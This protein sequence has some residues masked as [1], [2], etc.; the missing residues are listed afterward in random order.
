MREAFGVD[1]APQPLPPEPDDQPME[2]EAGVSEA[3]KPPSLADVW[4][5]M[6]AAAA[7]SEQLLA[8]IRS[9]QAT[10][11]A[12]ASLI[13]M[14]QQLAQEAAS[15]TIPWA[16]V[17][18]MVK[19]AL[20]AGGGRSS[21]EQHR[22]LTPKGPATQQARPAPMPTSPAAVAAIAQ[23][24]QLSHSPVGQAATVAALTAGLVYQAQQQ[25]QQQ[26]PCGPSF[27]CSSGAAARQGGHL[28]PGRP[29]QPSAPSPTAPG[30]S[31]AQAPL[32]LI[33]HAAAQPPRAPL[34]SMGLSAAPF[35]G[36][37]RV[38]AALSAQ[39][40]CGSHIVRDKVGSVPRLKKFVRKHAF[41][42]KRLSAVDLTRAVTTPAEE[43]LYWELYPQH[44]RGSRTNYQAMMREW[45]MRVVDSRLSQSSNKAIYLKQVHHLR[46]YEKK[47]VQQL[48]IRDA[49]RFNAALTQPSTPSQQPAP[50]CVLSGAP[51]L[52]HTPT[53]VLTS[54]S[55]P[56]TAFSSQA[57]AQA[58]A[59]TLAQAPTQPPAQANAF[60]AMAAA[61]QQ[62][63]QQQQQHSA[64]ALATTGVTALKTG[65]GRG[66]KGGNKACRGCR[67]FTGVEVQQ[68]PK[69]Q[70]V[71][72]HHKRFQAEQAAR[73]TKKAK[74]GN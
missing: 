25:A 60:T 51:S 24:Q 36:A 35:N 55:T 6:S 39:P 56:A 15:G 33:N 38:S 19:N 18:S 61:Q 14:L 70:E 13:S 21:Q 2:T 73:Q 49:V 63:H 5:L 37:Q 1:P 32:A 64:A 47:V 66:G 11:P 58:S 22:P 50:P 16:V 54:V 62:Q 10:Q 31:S 74:T 72:E 26:A 48:C 41:G 65:A 52:Q 43:Q 45:N 30:G 40:A 17:V 67:K 57:A 44:T 7:P 53:A 3:A 28:V 23:L 27:G 4:Q 34:A 42:F 12:E 69:H 9:L 46:L 59:P 71:C 68:T 20:Q 8:D 29:A